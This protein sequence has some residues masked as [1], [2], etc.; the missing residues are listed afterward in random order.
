MFLYYIKNLY[1]LYASNYFKLKFKYINCLR[2]KFRIIYIS[3]IK[4]F[5]NRYY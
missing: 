4:L 2:E 1:K 3:N 5:L